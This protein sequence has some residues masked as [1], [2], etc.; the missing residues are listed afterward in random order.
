MEPSQLKE[1]LNKEI[2]LLGRFRYQIHSCDVTYMA[3]RYYLAG[4]Y[5]L[6]G[7]PNPSDPAWNSHWQR[8]LTNKIKSANKN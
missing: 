1:R 2:R 5:R 3:L 8:P 7:T 4:H 6:Q